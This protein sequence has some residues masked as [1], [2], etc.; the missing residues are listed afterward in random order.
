MENLNQPPKSNGLNIKSEIIEGDFIYRLITEKDHYDKGENVKIYA[1]LEYIGKEDEV[2]ILHGGSPFLF[3]MNETTRKYEVDYAVTLQGL[4]TVL[5]KGEQLRQ[6][7]SGGGG[8]SEQDNEAYKEFMKKVMDQNY[9]S[10]HYVVNGYTNFT[11]A[12]E[13]EKNYTIEAQV[14]FY[15]ENEAKN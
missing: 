12:D 11:L 9:P 7:S 5:K 2:E 10:G 1:E 13:D 4:R 8:Y 15:V 14:E 6:E 3:P